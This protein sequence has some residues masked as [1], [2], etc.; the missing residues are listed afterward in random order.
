MP[1]S[2]LPFTQQKIELFCRPLKGILEKFFFSFF[3]Y[4]PQSLTIALQVPSLIQQIRHHAHEG[5][6]LDLTTLFKLI[7]VET[8]FEPLGSEKT[9]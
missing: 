6:G 5:F 2:D 1:D 3:S 9:D 8:E 4:K 7:Q